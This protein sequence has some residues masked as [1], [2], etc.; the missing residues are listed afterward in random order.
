MTLG[1]EE[2]ERGRSV[3]MN[4]ISSVEYL[5]SGILSHDEKTL[6]TDFMMSCNHKRKVLIDIP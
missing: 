5:E 3:F 2:S 6:N 1:A 4:W